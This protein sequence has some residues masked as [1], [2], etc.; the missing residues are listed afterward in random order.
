MRGNLIS[1]AVGVHAVWGLD[2]MD[3]VWCRVGLND[4]G[5]RGNSWKSVEGT[6]VDISVG[7]TGLVWGVGVDGRTWYRKGTNRLNPIGL[8][9]VEIQCGIDGISSPPNAMKAISAGATQ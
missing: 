9:W 5:P 2:E 1:L 7:P 4:S 3:T 8:E 6:M